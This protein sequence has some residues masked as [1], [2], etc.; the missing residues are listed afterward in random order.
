MR[1]WPICASRDKNAM[2]S[3]K[4]EQLAINF[5]KTIMEVAEKVSESFK[6]MKVDIQ[7]RINVWSISEVLW[8]KKVSNFYTFLVCLF[9]QNVEEVAAS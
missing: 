2:F 1:D 8:I 5:R 6:R 7:N 4:N 9:C 3:L